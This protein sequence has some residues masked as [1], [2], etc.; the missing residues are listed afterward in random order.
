M[1]R[2]FFFFLMI[3]FIGSIALSQRNMVA[4]S[5]SRSI[6]SI[7]IKGNDPFAPPTTKP[8]STTDAFQTFSVGIAAEDAVKNA[9]DSVM[10]TINALDVQSTRMYTYQGT[11]Q[12]ITLNNTAVSPNAGIDTTFYFS[13]INSAGEYVKSTGVNIIDSMFVSGQAIVWLHKFT[14]ENST[15]TVTI[16][17]G[18][19]RVTS[20]NGTEFIPLST[21]TGSDITTWTILASRDTVG[22]NNTFSFTV[23]PRDKYSNINTT[24]F[25][26]VNITANTGYNFNAGGNPVVIVG[27][28]TFNASELTATVPPAHLIIYAIDLKGNILGQSKSI[29]CKVG[30]SVETPANTLPTAYALSQNYPNPFNPTTNI[31][32][33][34][35][36]NSSVK[37]AVYDMLGREV[38][39]LVNTNYTPGHYTVPFDAS[40][41]SSGM[42]IYRITSQSTSGDQKMFTSA[43]KLML[44]K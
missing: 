23:Y 27:P 16:T 42:Y 22:V 5:G 38:A 24:T 21:I 1:K 12:T 9:G 18:T 25:C 19:I 41:L 36:Q 28:T 35:P 11:G 15:N 2:L 7:S 20:A 26:T 39:T 40:K 33:D 14:A 43:K 8:Q 31:M 44:V 6:N 3:T 10:I 34:I 29:V 32:F 37:I 17:A 30:V 4:A 13:Y